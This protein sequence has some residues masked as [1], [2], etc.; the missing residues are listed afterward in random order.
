MKISAPSLKLDMALQN[1][2][3]KD[4]RP[5]IVSRIGV[6]EATTDLS[7]EDVIAIL[8]CLVRPSVLPAFIRLTFGRPP[9][10]Q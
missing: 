1:I 8:K 10:E 9:K 4:G 5:I 2:V 3:V 7:R 6:Y